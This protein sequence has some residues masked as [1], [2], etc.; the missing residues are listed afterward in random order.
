MFYQ[1]EGPGKS[2]EK[3]YVPYVFQKL[4]SQSLHKKKNPNSQDLEEAQK[5]QGLESL[6]NICKKRLKKSRLMTSKYLKKP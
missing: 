5:N 1:L 2:R 3:I 4:R 6:E